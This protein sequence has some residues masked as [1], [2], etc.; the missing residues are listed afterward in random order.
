[1]KVNISRT[2][3]GRGVYLEHKSNELEV[4]QNYY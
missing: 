3:S 1:M 2:K 4:E